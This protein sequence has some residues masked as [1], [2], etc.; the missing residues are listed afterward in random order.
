[1]G[2]I[3]GDL[4]FD[5]QHVR[6]KDF[7]LEKYPDVEQAENTNF[8][9]SH[10]VSTQ[11]MSFSRGANEISEVNPTCES[12]LIFPRRLGRGIDPKKD[13]EESKRLT[14]IKKG[15]YVRN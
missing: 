10:N 3:F 9:T 8:M 6:L 7:G 5:Q 4:L 1:M 12:F 11:I 2:G 14:K 15:I 13:K